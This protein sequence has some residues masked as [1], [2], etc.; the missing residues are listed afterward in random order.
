[1]FAEKRSVI[2]VAVVLVVCG[3]LFCNANAVVEARSSSA[4]TISAPSSAKVNQ[5]FTLS[6]TLTA[7][8]AALTKQTV[9]LQRL[10]GTTWTTLASQTATIGTYSFSRTETTATTYQYRTV[11]AGAAP[12]A[13]SISPT[14]TVTVTAVDPSPTPTPTLT[15]TPTPTTITI[16]ASTT[17]PAVSQPFTLSGTLTA[18]GTPLSGKTIVLCRTDPAGAYSQPNSTTTNANGAYTFTL[19]ES[20]Q[21]IYYYAAAFPGD[22]YAASNAAVKITV[23]N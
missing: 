1:M 12:Y 15:P 19:S 5:P 10:S 22:T 18:N 8:G 11:Y 21:G 2:V 14:V 17:N 23:G 9:S 3:L 7:N 4:L 13:S 16:T 6:G 20:A